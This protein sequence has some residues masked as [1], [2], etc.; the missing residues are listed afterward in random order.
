MFFVPPA[1][2]THSASRV[3]ARRVQAFVQKV[4]RVGI[5]PSMWFTVRPGL[6]RHLRAKLCPRDSCLWP[7]D[8]CKRNILC[9]NSINKPKY[10]N[11]V[12]LSLFN[13]EY[14][15]TFLLF[16][17]SSWLA[18]NWLINDI[19]FICKPITVRLQVKCMYILMLWSLVPESSR[20]APDWAT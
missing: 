1:A 16:M 5:W 11:S 10:L 6:C 3:P 7:R 15:L 12:H 2:W 20:D 17:H 18:D 9:R 14:A 19:A 4:H 13:A 8:T